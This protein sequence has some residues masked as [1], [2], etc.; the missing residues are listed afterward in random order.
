MTNDDH[1][2]RLVAALAAYRTY[3]PNEVRAFID[4]PAQESINTI[5]E[6]LAPPKE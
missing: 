2:A 4:P 5:K 3:A 1:L 6:A